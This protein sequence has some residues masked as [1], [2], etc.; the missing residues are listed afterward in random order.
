MPKRRLSYVHAGAPLP[1]TVNRKIEDGNWPGSPRNSLRNQHQPLVLP[2]HEPSCPKTSGLAV[3]VNSI[4][5]KAPDQKCTSGK[6]ER[7]D[8]PQTLPGPPVASVAEQPRPPQEKSNSGAKG[9]RMRLPPRPPLP[10]W[11]A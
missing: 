2:L 7:V 8:L 4:A 3:V 10:K 5:S 11:D 1:G 9:W 6:G